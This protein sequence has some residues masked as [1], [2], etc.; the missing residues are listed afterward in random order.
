M[1]WLGTV[2]VCKAA[3]SPGGGE[4]KNRVYS[5]PSGKNKVYTCIFIRRSNVIITDVKIPPG[6]T[7]R[8]RLCFPLGPLVPGQS[9]VNHYNIPHCHQHSTASS[10]LSKLSS[11]GESKRIPAS[12][13]GENV[14]KTSSSQIFLVLVPLLDNHWCVFK[15]FVH[16]VQNH[17]HCFHRDH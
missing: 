3:K 5:S 14:E 1:A 15:I 13:N 11:P 8:S 7:R 2:W 9:C 12:K 6:P 17:P 10:S 16:Q 4:R